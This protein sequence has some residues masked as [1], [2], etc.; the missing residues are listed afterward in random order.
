MANS[1]QNWDNGGHF[2]HQKTGDWD[3]DR[4]GN[5]DRDINIEVANPK[6]KTKQVS[7]QRKRKSQNKER[8][9]IRKDI[10]ELESYYDD[11]FEDILRQL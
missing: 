6:S 4:S 7:R 9:N 1:P 10:L 11:Y 3:I 2:G 8:K 5:V